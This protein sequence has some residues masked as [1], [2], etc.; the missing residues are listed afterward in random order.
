MRLECQPLISFLAFGTCM[1]NLSWHAESLPEMLAPLVLTHVYSAVNNVTVVDSL[2]LTV[3]LRPVVNWC[4]FKND[5]DKVDLLLTPKAFSQSIS[6]GAFD[7]KSSLEDCISQSLI[8]C[9]CT[10]VDQ[11]GSVI[12]CVYCLQM[13]GGYVQERFYNRYGFMLGAVPD[14]VLPCPPCVPAVFVIAVFCDVASVGHGYPDG[15]RRSTDFCVTA[16]ARPEILPSA[17]HDGG[18]CGSVITIASACRRYPLK[19]NEMRTPSQLT[20]Y[21]TNSL[22]NPK[23]LRVPRIHALNV[24]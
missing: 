23:L 10:H 2:L 1:S 5:V 13:S 16:D 3:R 14:S 9:S 18:A 22:H 7:S 6:M 17:Q 19:S 24:S 4:N 11:N 20:L 15:E 12:L 8:S 21:T